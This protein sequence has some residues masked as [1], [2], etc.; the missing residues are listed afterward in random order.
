MSQR[1]PRKRR[2]ALVIAPGVVTAVELEPTWRGPRAGRIAECELGPPASDGAWPELEAALVEIV[3]ELGIAGCVADVLLARPYAHVKVAALPPVRR[4]DLRA[5]LQ[6]SAR[7]WF[8]LP[9]GEVAAEAL[10]LRAASQWRHVGPRRRERW[11]RR[12]PSRDSAEFP[13]TAT[14]PRTAATA[15]ALVAPEAVVRAATDAVTKAGLRVGVVAPVSLAVAALALERAGRRALARGFALLV[16]GAG[17]AER[18]IVRG[19]APRLFQPLPATDRAGP[20]VAVAPLNDGADGA[21][22]GSARAAGDNAGR[23]SDAVQA[24]GLRWVSSLHPVVAGGLGAICLGEQPL[25]LPAALRDAWM[26]RV[27]RRA[28]ARAAA[29]AALLMVAAAVHLRGLEAELAAVQAA[30]R[31]VAPGVERARAARGAVAAVDAMLARVQETNAA[32]ANWAAVFARIANALPDSAHLVSFRA[33]DDEVRLGV[34]AA[35]AA[36]AA[37]ALSAGGAFDAVSL[38]GPVRA[39]DAGGRERFELAARLAHAEG[40]ADEA[41]RDEAAPP[42]PRTDANGERRSP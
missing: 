38:A 36:A 23:T 30:R 19:G 33:E 40:S 42:A 18:I 34:V 7:R 27:R 35:S 21:A 20:C 39:A 5:L 12:G 1:T 41:R 17:W 26:K 14:T 2:L 9:D 10:P 29:A 16:R 37:A 6:R 11:S 25:L 8:P 28:I 32:T 24:P 4:R 13:A 3:R 31:A 15:I 22:A